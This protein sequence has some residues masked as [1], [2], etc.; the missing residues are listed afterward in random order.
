MPPF[1]ISGVNILTTT[2][3]S[4][5]TPPHTHTHTHTYVGATLGEEL[6]GRETLDLDVA[7]LVGRRVHLGD[8]D[9]LMILV[10][11][12]QLVPRRR[13][14]FAVSAPGRVE[15]DQHVLVLVESHVIEVLS[16]QNLDRLRVPVIRDVLRHQMRLQ[17]RKGQLVTF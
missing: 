4:R 6:D 17:V 13:Q 14:L 16:D 8:D 1:K 3:E 2:T 9:A 5:V 12:A 10:G 15:L 7:Q 11:L